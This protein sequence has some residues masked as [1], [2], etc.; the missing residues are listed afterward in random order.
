VYNLM[1]FIWSA[2]GEIFDAEKEAVTLEGPGTRRALRFL[3]ELVTQHHVSSPD[4]TSYGEYTAPQM[5]ATGKAALALGGS[6]ESDI[7]LDASGWGDE[8]FTQR[9]G[10]VAPPSAPD[11]NPASTVGGTSYV[12]LRQC[13]S[14]ALVMDVLKTV[15][16]PNVVG[17]LYRSI[18]QN[19]PSPSFNALLNP[20][21]DPL[22]TQTSRMI[23]SGHARPAIPE[24]VKIS[25]QL[26]SLFEATLSNSAPIDDIV[27]RTAEFIGA[28]SERPCQPQLA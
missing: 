21:T 16:D 4:V 20:E 10:Y 22:L 12:I 7:I 8:E 9:I 25:R 5:L 11:G 24:Y 15:T 27:H 18:L 19:L 23:A 6:Y 3:Q 1:S 17:M 26:Q 2:G 28:I 13:P 14:P